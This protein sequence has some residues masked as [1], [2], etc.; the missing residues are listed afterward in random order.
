MTLWQKSIGVSHSIFSSEGWGGGG[1][2]ASLI[3]V[4]GTIHKRAIQELMKRRL[5]KKAYHVPHTS[6]DSMNHSERYCHCHQVSRVEENNSDLDISESCLGHLELQINSNLD[7]S[8]L[9]E[10]KECT[11]RLKFPGKDVILC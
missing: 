6:F 10:S 3:S 9:S 7:T 1:V 5:A 4:K 2:G 11:G 8:V